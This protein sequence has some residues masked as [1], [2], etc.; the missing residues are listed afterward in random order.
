M[1]RKQEHSAISCRVLVERLKVCTVPGQRMLLLEDLLWK[2]RN[3]PPGARWYYTA[4]A[5]GCFVDAQIAAR[6]DMQEP[7]MKTHKAD[8]A[9]LTVI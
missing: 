7:V 4:R 6:L 1:P 8:V 5:L 2:S 3:L 9:L